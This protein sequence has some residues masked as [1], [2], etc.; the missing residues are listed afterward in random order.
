M[1][2]TAAIYTMLRRIGHSETGDLKNSELA[3]V[4]FVL[5]ICI[6]TCELGE[7]R[8]TA[9]GNAESHLF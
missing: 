4:C 6:G 8:F 2:A 3:I 9:Q 5:Y 7:P 1:V